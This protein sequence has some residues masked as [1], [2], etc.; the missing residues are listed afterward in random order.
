MRRAM[1]CSAL[2]L[3]CCKSPALAS[4]I[5]GEVVQVRISDLAFSPAE[6]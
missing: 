1:Q 5:A 2:V 3:G 4:A 6:I